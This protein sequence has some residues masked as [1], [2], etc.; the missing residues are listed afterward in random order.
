M[1]RKRTLGKVSLLLTVNNSSIAGKGDFHASLA[2]W[3]WLKP[4]VVVIRGAGISSSLKSSAASRLHLDH[5]LPTWCQASTSLHD[6]FSPGHQL[7]P[8][9]HLHQWPSMTSH[10]LRGQASSTTW[11]IFTHY[12]VQLQHKVQPWLSLEHN[13]FVLS[14]N[15]SQ[16]ISPK[17]CQSL[18]N[19]H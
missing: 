14:E 19:Q 11:V 16:K 12:K 2:T 17:C 1:G 10:V 8:R 13:F 18:L 7:Q 15:I 3:V 9:L 5:R 4:T 6:H